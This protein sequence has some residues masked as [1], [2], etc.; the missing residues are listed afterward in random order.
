MEAIPK[1]T[2]KVDDTAD[3]KPSLTD[4]V[5]AKRNDRRLKVNSKLKR[6]FQIAGKIQSFEYSKPRLRKQ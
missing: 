2:A 4:E 6:F 1:T 3:Q 5:K